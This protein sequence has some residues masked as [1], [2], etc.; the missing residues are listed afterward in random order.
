MTNTNQQDRYLEIL[1]QVIDRPVDYLEGGDPD[2]IIGL[3]DTLTA[4]QRAV[5]EETASLRTELERV[6]GYARRL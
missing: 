1:A 6:R 3:N 5:E 4:M 2:Y